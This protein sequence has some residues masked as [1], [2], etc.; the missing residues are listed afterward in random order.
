MN[1]NGRPKILLI[2]IDAHAC[3]PYLDAVLVSFSSPS[4]Q[5]Y[6]TTGRTLDGSVEYSELLP[7]FRF[8]FS[9][10]SSMKSG[11]SVDAE[12]Q[13]RQGGGCLGHSASWSLSRLPNTNRSDEGE[14]RR[15][16]PRRRL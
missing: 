4:P 9:H 13:I 2:E 16:A 12:H 15:F 3:Y 5:I 14:V 7:L 1:P 6:F 11:I 8:V 10:F